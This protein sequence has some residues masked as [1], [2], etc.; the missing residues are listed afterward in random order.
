MIVGQLE[1]C[2][3]QWCIKAMRSLQLRED[4]LKE[5]FSSNSSAIRRGWTL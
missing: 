1:E 5:C 2:E 3:C 4:G